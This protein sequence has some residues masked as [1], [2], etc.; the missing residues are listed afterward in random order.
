VGYRAG[1]DR[2]AAAERVDR[3]AHPTERGE[4]SQLAHRV[5]ELTSENVC[6]IGGLTECAKKQLA[7][8]HIGEP[9]VGIYC[10]TILISMDA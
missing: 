3:Q 7:L 5:E 8:R 10:Q 6:Q 4:S 9:K 2:P 1:A